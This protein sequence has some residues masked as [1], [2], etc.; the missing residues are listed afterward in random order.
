MRGGE[1]RVRLCT[2]SRKEG[3]GGGLREIRHLLECHCFPASPADD[4]HC[5]S[6]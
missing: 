4:I 3:G 6:R 2:E 1:G 5:L